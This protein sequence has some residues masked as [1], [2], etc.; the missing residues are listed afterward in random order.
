MNFFR[1]LVTSKTTTLN[2]QEA[3]ARIDSE[4]P[5]IILDVRQPDEYQA[6]HI[7][8][9]K[10]I[11]LNELPQRMNELPKDTEI[12]CVCRSG[13]R[14]GTASSQLNRAGFNALN[15]QGGM[16]GWQNAGYPVEKG[17]SC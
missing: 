5:L 1:P 15:L 8:G 13:A 2:A 6:G 16:M 7:A 17:T 4:Q 14:S 11:P 9:A 10:L 3:K 12:L